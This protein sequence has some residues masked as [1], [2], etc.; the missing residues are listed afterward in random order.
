MSIRKLC[1]TFEHCCNHTGY[2]VP[3]S[4]KATRPGEPTSIEVSQLLT[5][6]A[7]ELEE[8][9]DRIKELEAEKAEVDDGFIPGW[10]FD[11]G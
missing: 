7:N 6:F 5:W 9:R 4:Y 3:E 8:A 1:E 2:S 11:S 10:E